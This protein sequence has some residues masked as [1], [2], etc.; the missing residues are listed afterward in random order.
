LAI[1]NFGEKGFLFISSIEFKM[2]REGGF[3]LKNNEKIEK[4]QGKKRIF[5]I[6]D[7]RFRKPGIRES[8]K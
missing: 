5:L 4:Q 6:S 7:I 2:Q 1:E 8:E 3:S